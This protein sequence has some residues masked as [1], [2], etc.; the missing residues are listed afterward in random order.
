MADTWIT[1]ITRFLDEDGEII[2]EPIQ[3]MGCPAMWDYLEA[4]LEEER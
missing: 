1:D 3:A 2:S 4:S